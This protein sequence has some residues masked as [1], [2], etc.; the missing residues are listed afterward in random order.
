APALAA[1]VVLRVDATQAPRKIFYAE[2]TIPVTAGPL[3]LVF[4]KWI[5]GEHAPTGPIAD[6]AGLKFTAAGKTIE[7]K[8]DDVER[9]GFHLNIP[10]GVTSLDVRL[11]QLSAP[12]P[13][14]FSSAASTTS[15]LS[16]ISWNQL[17]LYPEG[18]PSDEVEFTAQLHLP[19]GWKFGTALPVAKTG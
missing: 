1:P 14:G 4:P 2:E 10:R 16:V 11:E 3:T 17:L 5:P 12:T 13:E 9:Y 6:L 7:W 18:K 8:R 19:D 15:E